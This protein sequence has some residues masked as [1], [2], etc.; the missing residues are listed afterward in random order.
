MDR[1]Y[2]E[3]DDKAIY[4]ELKLLLEAN[5]YEVVTAPPC[6]LALIDINLGGASGFE[7]CRNL[8]KQHSFPIIFLT[9]RTE[10]RDELMG[11]ALG[12]DDY[13]RKPYDSGV[14][15]ARIARLLKKRE[16]TVLKK[17]GLTLHLDT[18]HVMKDGKE[19]ELTKNEARILALLMKKDV[20]TKDEIISYMWDDSLYIDSS[21]L[22]VNLNR[23]R[24]K[25][26]EVGADDCIVNIR[27]VGYRL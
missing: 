7:I 22:Y 14:L 25:L 18:L 19:T 4:D 11:F 9:A 20:S 16:E 12:A 10:N 8:R 27:G 5:G 24:G 3:E 13:I 15:L 26:K 17:K 21:T 23:L 1:I 2:V 6:E